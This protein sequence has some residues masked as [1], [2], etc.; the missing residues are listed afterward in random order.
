MF[1]ALRFHDDV[2][3]ARTVGLSPTR[4]SARPVIVCSLCEPPSST[5]PLFVCFPCQKRD[6]N[7]DAMSVFVVG[8]GM[9]IKEPTPPHPPPAPATDIPK[10]MLV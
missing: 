5:V 1:H 8:R 4:T 9:N 2:V 10:L 7:S 6:I 3:L